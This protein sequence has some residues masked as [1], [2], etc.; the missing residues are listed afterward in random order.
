MAPRDPFANPELLVRRVY[1]YVAYRVGPGAEAEDLT[2]DALERALRYRDS[3]DAQKGEPH[4]WLIGIARRVVDGRPRAA[5]TGVLSA[6]VASATEI[7]RETMLRLRVRE[8][9]LA[10]D[11]RDRELI[12]LRYGAGLSPAEIAEFL[13]MKRNAVDVALHRARSR[14]RTALEAA[15]APSVLPET[16][17]AT[18]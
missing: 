5:A 3:F 17:S 7:E 1:A 13:D 16:G 14:L 10:L 12:A 8:A 4:T 15:E 2:N 6:D 18:G 11:Q 9:V